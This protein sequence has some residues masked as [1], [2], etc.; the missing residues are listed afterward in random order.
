[1]KQNVQEQ[2]VNADNGDP[3]AVGAA[4]I[5]LFA[6]LSAVVFWAPIMRK[7]WRLVTDVSRLV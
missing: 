5:V 7:G 2:K 6:V 4:L 3:G 1:V